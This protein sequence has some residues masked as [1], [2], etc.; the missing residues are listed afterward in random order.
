M[1]GMIP[2]TTIAEINSREPVRVRAKTPLIDVVLAMSKARRGATIIEDDAERIIGIFTERDLTSKIN[3]S[4]H[5]WHKV[6]VD[7]VMNDRPKTIK[8]TQFINE[9]LSIMITCR[10]RHLPVVD[11]D[12]HVLGI[13][14]IRDI[15][16]HVAKLYPKEFLNLPPRPDSEASDRYGG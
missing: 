6:T 7:Q 2:K 15:I 11:S 4:T 3:H 12:N 8:A 5:D 10:F 16:L 14:T 13:I 1:P 9:A